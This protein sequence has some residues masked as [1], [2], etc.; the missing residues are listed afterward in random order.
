M[1]LAR[2][3]QAGHLELLSNHATQGEFLEARVE[4]YQHDAKR[5]PMYFVGDH[6]GAA[7]LKPTAPKSGSATAFLRTKLQDWSTNP[8]PD[9]I[10][11]FP[12]K[13]ERKTFLK[14]FGRIL[15]NET[16]AAITLALFRKQLGKLNRCQRVVGLLGREISERY[17]EHYCVSENGEL[18]TGIA[19]LT[20]FDALSTMFP[21]YDVKVLGTIV[22]NLGAESLV[23]DELLD[24]FLAHRGQQ[25]HVLFTDRLR[26]F[27]GGLCYSSGNTQPCQPSGAAREIL[28]QKAL[29]FLQRVD[30]PLSTN[31][32]VI[33]LLF[34]FTSRLVETI[35][36]A[37]KNNEFAKGVGVMEN[38][39][40]SMRTTT[41]LLV[42]AAEVEHDAVVEAASRA[43]LPA[44]ERRFHGDH[45]YFELGVLGG[46]RLL[47]VKCSAGSGG[48]SGALP[49]LLDAVRDIGPDSIIMCGIAFGLKK[50]KQ[51]LCDILLSKQIMAYDLKRVTEDERGHMTITP[52]GDRPSASPRLYDRFWNGARDWNVAKVHEGLMLS[53]DTLV[54]SP[55]FKAELLRLEPEAIGG[56]M[57]A[58]AVYI[59]SLKAHI[60]WIVVKAI[61]DWG[62]KKDKRDQQ[63]AAKNAAS[64]VFHVIRQGGISQ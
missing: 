1:L 59:A 7:L 2:L 60:D 19:G 54:D 51:N 11:S 57:E 47:L 33:D 4:A 63:A 24:Q 42:V 58:S 53:G 22:Q 45:T 25:A 31:R 43:G 16:G 50:E 5:Y 12:G 21:F 23:S 29:R 34:A 64:L 38:E 46:C 62:E 28:R 8:S 55:T 27:L 39:V 36:R 37:M 52:R 35:D 48:P 3:A 41:V 30:R 17:T 6:A 49:T 44:Y 40:S 26:V 56:E 9:L 61:C 32:R 13:K 20:G 10:A 14:E 18:P 15:T